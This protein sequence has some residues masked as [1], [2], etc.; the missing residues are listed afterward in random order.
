VEY[1]PTLVLE[2]QR[3]RD[4]EALYPSSSAPARSKSRQIEDQLMDLEQML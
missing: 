3:R 2:T 1:P 4:A